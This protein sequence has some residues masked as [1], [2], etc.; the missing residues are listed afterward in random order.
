VIWLNEHLEDS[1]RL[2]NGFIS[3][4]GYRRTITAEE[5]KRTLL[6]SDVFVIQHQGRPVATHVVRV[7]GVDRARVLIGA[8]VERGADLP[9]GVIGALNRY[10]L[11][12][13]IGHYRSRGVRYF[14]FGGVTLDRASPLYSIAGSNCHSAAT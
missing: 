7:D 5:W 12:H 11:W 2:V 8:T 6:H 9:G 13:E 14:D 10:L 4:S 1:L 3:R